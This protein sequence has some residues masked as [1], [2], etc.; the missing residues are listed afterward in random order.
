[1]ENKLILEI[2]Q[3]RCNMGLSVITEDIQILLE[4][5]TSE[6]FGKMF[7]NLFRTNSRS[8]LKSLLSAE[9]K[10][11]VKQFIKD[12]IKDDVTKLKFSNFMKTSNGVKTIQELERRIQAAKVRRTNP[13]DAQTEGYMNSIVNK[14]KRAETEWGKKVSPIVKVDWSKVK[15]IT[16][17][18]FSRFLADNKTVGTNLRLIALQLLKKRPIYVGGKTIWPF[19]N[20]VDK[21]A[22]EMFGVLKTIEQRFNEGGGLQNSLKDSDSL[23]RDVQAS[24]GSLQKGVADFDKITADM[25]K[26]MTEGGVNPKTAN[27]ITSYIKSNDPWKQK[28]WLRKI[29]GESSFATAIKGIAS[30]DL[31][32]YQKLWNLAQRTLMFFT[33]GSIKTWKEISEFMIGRESSGVLK[34]GIQYYLFMMWVSNVVLPLSMSVLGTIGAM[35]KGGFFGYQNDSLWEEYKKQVKEYYNKITTAPDGNTNYLRLMIPWTWFWDDVVDISNK[36]ISGSVNFMSYIDKY[37][38]HAKEAMMK[39]LKLEKEAFDKQV[40]EWNQRHRG[41]GVVEEKLTEITVEAFYRKYPC[42]EKVIDKTYGDRG[43]KIIDTNTIE[44]KYK[45]IELIYKAELKSDGKL[46]WENSTTELGC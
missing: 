30:K 8:V 44:I 25:F 13:I 18:L 28:S 32:W 1:M 4:S 16:P 46:Y 2:N 5:P 39:E 29:V 20:N 23:F 3:I 11:L 7:D 43:L 9:E 41:Q 24:L 19:K 27:L 45:D 6:V 34:G 42:Y 35:I 37:L 26:V 22:E 33:T 10:L 15:E 12:E 14:M 38:I 36:M 40:K 21:V 31:K 17:S